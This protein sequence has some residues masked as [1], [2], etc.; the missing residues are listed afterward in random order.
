MVLK[1]EMESLLMKGSKADHGSQTDQTEADEA[2]ITRKVLKGTFKK[3]K[4]AFAEDEVYT[5]NAVIQNIAE[6]MRAL[7]MKMETNS[8]EGIAQ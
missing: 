4:A 2:A 5:T 8:F 3:L 7:N 1:S 6:A